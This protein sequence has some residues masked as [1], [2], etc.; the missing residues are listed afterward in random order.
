MKGPREMKSQNEISDL[1]ESVTL[2]R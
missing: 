1:T 2:V